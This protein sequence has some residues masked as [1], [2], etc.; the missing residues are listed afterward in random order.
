[1]TICEGQLK[2]ASE[3]RTNVMTAQCILEITPATILNEE[4]RKY[5]IHT[6]KYKSYKSTFLLGQCLE[7]L[8]RL[9]ALAMKKGQQLDIIFLDKARP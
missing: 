5:S 4:H 3:R 8:D 2:E 6:R 9:L 1:M 7:I